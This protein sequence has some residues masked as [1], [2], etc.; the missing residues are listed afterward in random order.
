M[1]PSASTKRNWRGLAFP[2]CANGV[3]VPTSMKPKPMAPKPSIASAFLSAPAAKPIG[4]LNS[5]P[6]TVLGVP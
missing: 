3:T 6:M 4:F 1:M 2:S 5:I